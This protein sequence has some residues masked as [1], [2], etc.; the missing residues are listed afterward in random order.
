VFVHVTAATMLVGGSLTAVPLIR[1]SLRRAVTVPELSTTVRFART[2][3]SINPISAVVLL[4]S[5][6]VITTVTSLWGAGWVQVASGLAV[7]TVYAKRYLEP[8]IHAL[9]KRN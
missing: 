2:L 8:T 9:T 1:G 5:G 3:G 4:A 6:V 7:N